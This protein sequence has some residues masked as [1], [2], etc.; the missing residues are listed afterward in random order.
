MSKKKKKAVPK[1]KVVII[2]DT[3]GDCGFWINVIDP[4]EAGVGGCSRR[5]PQGEPGKLVVGWQLVKNSR[6]KCG[7]H[8]KG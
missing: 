7:D 3:C 2:D 6:P 5:L 4:P 1:K 8:I